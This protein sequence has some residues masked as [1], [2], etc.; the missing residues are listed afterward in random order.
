MIRISHQSGFSTSTY[1]LLRGATDE[2][3]MYVPRISKALIGIQIHTDLRTTIRQ[4]YTYQA[5]QML[6][7]CRAHEAEYQLAHALILFRKLDL[8]AT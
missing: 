7:R 4:Q 5:F 6:I 8:C 2:E 3:V 1:S